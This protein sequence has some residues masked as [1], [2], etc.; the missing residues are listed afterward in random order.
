MAGKP[1]QVVAVHTQTIPTAN[2]GRDM[3]TYD[4]ELITRAVAIT[5]AGWDAGSRNGDG[6]L[7]T[8]LHLTPLFVDQNP[9]GR[10]GSLDAQG[11]SVIPLGVAETCQR[12]S[13]VT[14]EEV[15]EHAGVGQHAQALTSG[16]AYEAGLVLV[17]A[18]AAVQ[19]DRAVEHLVQPLLV[20]GPP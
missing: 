12:H 10:G 14:V 13:H 19:T 16:T 20:A 15:Q 3:T 7:V 18:V 11:E 4:T 17:S 2:D 9:S 8:A 6:G 5:G 1:L